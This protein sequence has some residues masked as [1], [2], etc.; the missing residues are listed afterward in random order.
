MEY[1]IV[2]KPEIK[3]IGIECLTDVEECSG[4]NNPAKAL[5]KKF[6][7]RLGEIKHRKGTLFYGAS[8]VT[9]ECSFRYMAA[10][11]VENFEDIP[12]GMVKATAPPEKYAVW[13]HKGR[14]ETLKNTYGY[15]YEKGMPESGL[16]QKKDFWLEMYDERFKE[17]SDDSEMDLYIPVE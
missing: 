1:K 12:E 9:G 2:N 8:F 10:V 14:L 11:E 5:W 17:D 13:T 3:L 7:E 6:M 16:K 4:P 15:L